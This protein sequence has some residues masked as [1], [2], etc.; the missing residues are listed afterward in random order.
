[1]GLCVLAAD[2]TGFSPEFV[3]RLRSSWCRGT[4]D[5]CARFLAASVVGREAVPDDLFPVEYERAARF[6]AG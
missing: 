5:Q 4:Y 6:L 1:M 2:E 3:Q